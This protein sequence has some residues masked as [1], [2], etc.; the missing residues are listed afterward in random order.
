M[1]QSLLLT[2]TLPIDM[3]CTCALTR[4]VAFV[5]ILFPGHADSSTDQSSEPFLLV[6]TNAGIQQT[7]LS[8][9]Q[10]H[11]LY[12]TRTLPVAIDFLQKG[13]STTVFWSDISTDCISAGEIV[14]KRLQNVRTVVSGGL[15]SVEGLAVDWLAC[16]LYW[17]ESKHQEI[18]VAKCDG[19]QRS[20][21]IGDVQH[22]RGLALDPRA[23]FLF[24]SDWDT[25][26]P[27]IERSRMDGSE[28]E[29]IAHVQSFTG[30]PKALPSGITLDYE[31]HKVYW[32]DA[33]S[34]SIHTINYDGSGHRKIL[35][36]ARFSKP[37]SV[38]VFGDYFYWTDITCL[39]IFKANRYSQ[40]TSQEVVLQSNNTFYQAV[41]V[42]PS[43]HPTS[44]AKNVCAHHNGMC[45][46]LCVSDG[47]FPRCTCP[48]GLQLSS[49]KKSCQAHGPLLVYITKDTLV[50]HFL[51]ASNPTRWVYPPMK[52][53]TSV[54]SAAF[55]TRND[56]LYW[57]DGR[58]IQRHSLKEGSSD[59]FAEFGSQVKLTALS[60]DSLSGNLY[61]GGSVQLNSDIRSHISVCSLS[62]RF[63][64]NLIW[65]KVKHVAAIGLDPTN[66]LVF[67]MERERANTE[68]DSLTVKVASMD[69]S[70]QRVLQSHTFFRAMV[71]KGLDVNPHRREVCWGDLSN[72]SVSCV[73][74]DITQSVQEYLAIEDA[75][76]ELEF[77]SNQQEL[78]YSV[79]NGAVYVRSYSTGSLRLFFNAS[80]SLAYLKHTAADMYPEQTVAAHPCQAPATPCRGICLAQDSGHKCIPVGG[81]DRLLI[82][83]QNR[84]P[85]AYA[86][87]S[88]PAAPPLLLQA[89]FSEMTF[90]VIH[91]VAEEET[92]VCAR[93]HQI[94]RSRVDGYNV[95]LVASLPGWRVTA[96]AFD[97]SQRLLYR[98]VYSASGA[99]IEVSGWDDM[100]T[101]VV[102]SSNLH[103]VISL[104]VHPF[105]KLLFWSDAGQWPQ[106][107]RMDLSSGSREVV[108]KEEIIRISDVVVDVENELLYW[109]DLG[110]ARIERARLDGTRRTGILLNKSSN[111]HYLPVSVATFHSILFWLDSTYSGGSLVMMIRNR[112]PQT[113]I[114]SRY[115]GPNV[116]HLQLYYQRMFH[117]HNETNDTQETG[118]SSMMTCSGYCLHS[119][120]CTLEGNGSPSCQCQSN[121]TGPRCQ[122]YTTYL[123]DPSFTDEETVDMKVIVVPVAVLVVLFILM[124]VAA[125]VKRRYS[126]Q[127]SVCSLSSEEENP[128]L[129]MPMV[130]HQYETSF[131]DNV[132]LMG[133]NP[134]FGTSAPN[135]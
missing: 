99:R 6:T 45:S 119:G 88:D 8:M 22:P 75:S 5:F 4:L 115:L 87:G 21:I 32:I 51:L 77:T 76:G 81:S 50:A 111:R 102:L 128:A 44:N 19:S 41:I 101:S 33:R 84:R 73:S 93:H 124:L 25:E 117:S 27:R 114:W 109:C 14:N 11:F 46:H 16:N 63:C 89:T 38:D 83:L 79:G 15:E 112:H 52:I 98:G 118:S 74:Y 129:T 125:W 1:N 56:V 80:Q 31:M 40:S 47:S 72:S 48:Y 67:W 39:S 85:M 26:D 2:V 60:L 62:D 53:S 9:K 24:W 110:T 134:A 43:R 127:S 7:Y 126:W 30:V 132:L 106:I 13:N 23:G 122:Y 135:A 61:V 36:L 100:D 20:S 116:S 66:R 92:V 105:R 64:S 120:T 108:I 130:D 71:T 133:T 65:D 82:F 70:S 97:A 58:S 12:D 55:D 131:S 86:M 18:E 69:G 59:T 107:E 94:F 96:L 42:H 91:T 78:I 29:I 49:D 34:G 54:L 68:E 28:R 3:F 35:H 10:S 113:S 103:K 57:I 95:T 123:I 17:I 90:D 121:F 104:A 37:F